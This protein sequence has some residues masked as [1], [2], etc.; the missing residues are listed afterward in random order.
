MSGNDPLSQPSEHIQ[1]GQEA[2]AS[3]PS[4]AAVPPLLLKAE[5]EPASSWRMVTE[6]FPLHPNF[7]WA[8]LWCVGLIFCTQIPGAVVAV[9]ILLGGMLLFPNE[10]SMEEMG[11]LK[12][13][14]QN[15][16]GQISMG[17]AI[18][19]AHGLIILFALV[20]LR[21]LAGRDW[22]R[23]VALRK[24]AWTHVG[25]GVLVAPAFIVLGNGAYYVIRHLL[26]VPSIFSS[27]GGGGTG[28]LEEA[29]RF[30]GW[31]IP[32][33]VFCIAALPAMSEE[34]WCRAFLGR[35]L[36]GKHGVV[37]GVLGTS[38]LFG[39]IHVDPAQGMMAMCMGVLLHFVYLTTRSL[40]MPMLLHF[41]NNSAAVILGSIP[42]LGA[43]DKAQPGDVL[44]LYSGA[45]V[46]LVGVCWAFYQSRARLVR[47]EEAAWQPAYPGVAC[48][49]PDSGT[50]I[51]TPALSEG[52][53]VGVLAGLAA[54]IVGLIMAMRAVSAMSG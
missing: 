27:M 40:L 3:S 16:I 25:L 33:A 24:P 32:G 17:A 14:L 23:Q 11:D 43:L 8:I 45:A 30:H 21:I 28:E 47:E 18:V 20:L 50:H 34:L 35:G 9:V 22:P 42:A 49:P 36:V 29:L 39:V 10:L 12:S 38:F 5:E 52:S 4:E 54:F 51:E 53:V 41:L 15:P 7:W 37:L 26:G 31:A 44:S 46:L 48:P 19:V 6:G 13:L 1:P 2:M